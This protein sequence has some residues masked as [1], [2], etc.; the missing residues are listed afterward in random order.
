MSQRRPAG[1][2]GHF[3]KR[4]RF[5]RVVS[6]KGVTTLVER[7]QSVRFLVGDPA[8]SLGTFLEQ[9]KKK[10]KDLFVRPKDGHDVDGFKLQNFQLRHRLLM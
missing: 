3:V 9:E 5:F 4:L 10:N 7:S 6:D 1:D 8:F 2:N